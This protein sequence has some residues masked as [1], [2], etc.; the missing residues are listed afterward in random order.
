QKVSNGDFSVRLPVDQDGV[1]RSIC[2]S[3]NKVIDLNERLT[4]ELGR[5][6]KT[7]GKQGKLNQKIQLDGSRGSWSSCVEI[8]NELISDMGRPTIEIAHV[9]TSVAKGNLD[10]E[11]PLTIEG[12]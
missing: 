11:M 6:G 5:V 9:I 2:E 12:I 8:V 7:I 3:L 4:L 10:E 1:K